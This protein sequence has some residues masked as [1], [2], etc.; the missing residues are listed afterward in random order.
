MKAIRYLA[1]GLALSVLGSCGTLGGGGG[2]GLELSVR[3]RQARFIEK[4]YEPVYSARD[5]GDFEAYIRLHGA[6][7][8]M[9]REP[10]LNRHDKIT[11]EMVTLRYPGYEMRY[12][13]YS[14]RGLW[15]PPR[16]L[17]MAVLS[18]SGGKYL[19]GIAR[20]MDRRA[21]NEILGL[22]ESREPG[23]YVYELEGHRVLLTFKDEALLGILWDYSGD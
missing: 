2:S 11:D 9:T 16:S 21:V 7:E 10:I 5:N 6:P 3:E 15:H 13:A 17:L 22:A 14:P 12:L 23:V 8:A 19:F 1:V 20:G 4:G 18:R